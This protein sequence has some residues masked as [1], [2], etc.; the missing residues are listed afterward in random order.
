MRSGLTEPH[1]G[2]SP[3]TQLHPGA[4]TPGF[5]RPGLPRAPTSIP[6]RTPHMHDRSGGLAAGTVPLG[7]QSEEPLPLLP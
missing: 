4:E 7:S 1:S 3:G 5:L 2:P 6:W